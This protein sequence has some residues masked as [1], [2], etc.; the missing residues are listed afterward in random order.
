MTVGKIFKSAWQLIKETFK[1]FSQHKI[2]KMSG[3]LA[4]YTVFSMAPM[5]IVIIALCGFFLEREAIEGEVFGVLRGFMGEDTALQLQ[6]IIKN[7]A[8]T[9]KKNLAAII[10]GITLLVGATTVFAEIQDSINDIWGLKPKAKL[11]WLLILKNRL[12][13]FSVIIGL[14]FILLVSL[15]ITGLVESFNER[16]QKMFPDV[17][18]LLFYLLNLVI[19]LGISMLIFAVIFKVLPDAT[20]RWKDVWVGAFVTALLF[21]LGKFGISLYVSNSNIGSTF[22]A[23]GSL[24]VMLIWIYYSSIILFIGAEF[25]RAWAF[26]YGEEIRPNRYAVTTR[27]V[28]VELGK[29][30][31]NAQSAG[32]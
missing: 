12:L 23:A 2:T 31:V 11:G 21:L 25:T 5:L 10:G 13:S 22:G 6:E 1:G 26:L 24:A 7:A 4:Y 15:T 20:I 18:L 29:A 9:G 17:A 32:E 3:S 30:P 28:E 14:G 19:T 27:E 8:L 16:L